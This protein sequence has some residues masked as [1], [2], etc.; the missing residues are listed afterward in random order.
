[1]Q[2]VSIKTELFVLQ[3]IGSKKM[4]LYNLIIVLL[5]FL[6]VTSQNCIRDKKGFKNPVG[7]DTTDVDTT[8]ND[9]T[10][11]YPP[12]V[13]QK[14]TIDSFE[15]ID[16]K[17]TN[18]GQ[19]IAT[20][21]K[22][23]GKYGLLTKFDEQFNF[24]WSKN[25][26]ELLGGGYLTS[27][28]ALCSDGG[29]VYLTS[30]AGA[31]YI[32]IKTD[33]NG[34]VVW[35]KKY[36]S[37]GARIGQ[38]K[39]TRDNGYLIVGTKRGKVCYT[40]IDPDYCFECYLNYLIKTDSNGDTLWTKTLYDESSSQPRDL[41]GVAFVET[42]DGF[43]IH[44]RSYEGELYLFK[45]DL[46]GNFEWNNGVVGGTHCFLLLHPETGII[47]G[48]NRKYLETMNEVRLC[49]VDF[50]G[51]LIW[52]AEPFPQ[53]EANSALFNSQNELVML[54][55]FLNCQTV[56]F[57]FPE[58][59]QIWLRLYNS[60]GELLSQWLYEDKKMT[61]GKRI[62]MNESGNYIII[63]QT[64][65]LYSSYYF[66]SEGLIFLEVQSDCFD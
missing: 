18:D 20:S 43:Y 53:G 26:P 4:K 2:A 32:C 65:H 50:D 48:T 16:V 44:S 61:R 47:I 7:A 56:M 63:G 60:S 21:G 62:F 19:Y 39:Q 6:M 28:L 13:L 9:T 58:T 51:N 46:N 38:V 3:F 37:P 55:T 27:S 45:T 5:L 8:D 11:N 14:K 64:G 52:Q 25:F 54:A 36:D 57:C 66:K 40:Q 41:F 12:F 22:P 49:Y 30:I 33:K 34:E 15:F 17:R 59:F 23:V 1:V 10:N 31:K 42:A 35:Q 24:L 29:Y